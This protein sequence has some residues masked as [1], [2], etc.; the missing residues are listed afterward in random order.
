MLRMCGME[1][2]ILSVAIDPS[3]ASVSPGFFYQ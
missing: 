2:N 3:F 1:N